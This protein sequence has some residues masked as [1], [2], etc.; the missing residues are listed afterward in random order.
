MFFEVKGRYGWTIHRED[1]QKHKHGK[2]EDGCPRNDVSRNKNSTASRESTWL[3]R[4]EME[5]VI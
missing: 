1:E 4:L 5:L 3:A 2:A